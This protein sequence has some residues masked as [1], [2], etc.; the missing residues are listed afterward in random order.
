MLTALKALHVAGALDGVT[1]TIALTGDEELPVN[2]LELS[3]RDLIEAAR[4]HNAFHDEIRSEQYLTFYAG[5]ILGGTRADFD[6]VYS[7]GEA[8]GNWKV[9]LLRL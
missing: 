2:P 7:N 3:R 9:N 4:I 5:I 8:F 6:P 1:I